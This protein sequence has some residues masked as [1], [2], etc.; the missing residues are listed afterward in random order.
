MLGF[1]P[2]APILHHSILSIF[3]SC[4]SIAEHPL[5]KRKT[6][7]RYLPG[8]PN[9]A[10]P[11]SIDFMRATFRLSDPFPVREGGRLAACRT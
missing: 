10:K 5:D 9:S 2:A 1:G 3:P 4:S 6:Q 8:R 7:E 11:K